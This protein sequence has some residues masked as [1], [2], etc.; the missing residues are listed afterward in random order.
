MIG[1]GAEE[2][3]FLGVDLTYGTL[4][5]STGFTGQDIPRDVE[6][7]NGVNRTGHTHMTLVRYTCAGCLRSLFQTGQGV[8][9]NDL[10][11]MVLMSRDQQSPKDMTSADST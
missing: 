5:L 2:E 9:L 1:K 11:G 10:R 3:P 8:R 7:V 4:G 6:I